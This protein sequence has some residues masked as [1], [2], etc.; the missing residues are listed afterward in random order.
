M[1]VEFKAISALELLK[2]Q[3]FRSLSSEIV[4][5]F[6]QLRAESN[7]RVVLG[8]TLLLY[9]PFPQIMCVHTELFSKKKRSE[10]CMK[11]CRSNRTRGTNVT[12][13]LQEQKKNKIKVL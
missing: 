12:V 10:V 6:S 7:T 13:T 5:K 9:P 11:V 3:A 1:K 8:E 2:N 4:F